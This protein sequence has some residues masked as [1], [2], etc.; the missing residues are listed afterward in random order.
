MATTQL[1]A[2]TRGL[3]L[4]DGI[5]S[6]KPDEALILNNWFPR[7]GYCQLRGG[8][9]SYATGLGSTVQSI[10]EWSGPATRKMFGATASAI[11]NT[12]SSGAVG[13]ADLSSLTSGYWQS[14]NFTTAGGA[15]LVICNGADSVRNYDGT[16]W[17][18]PSIT[19]VTSADLI[20]VAS[21]KSRLWF[22]QKD[23][24][25]AWYLGTSSISGAATSFEL[26]ERFTLGGALRAIGSIST[27]AGDAGSDDYL[28][29]VSSKGEVVV[30]R[31]TDPSSANT[32]ALVGVYRSA[33]PIGHRCLA[34]IGGDLG[35]LTEGGIVSV[36][37]LIAGGRD[38]AERGAVTARID[39]A[40]AD[41]FT[42]Y[43]SVT[44][45]QMIV[46]PRTRQ[47]IFNVP[48]STTE[49][50]Q[51]AMNVKTGAWCTYTSLNATCWG[52][53]NE[54]LY[55]GS[56]AG[57]VWK[58]EDGSADNGAAITGEIKYSFQPFGARGG[59]S[60]I[61]QVRPLF[62]AS[63]R[64][65]PAVRVDIDYQN[66][67][68]TSSDE[69]PVTAGTLGSAWDVG[70]WDVATWGDNSQLFGDWV[71]A[72]GIGT[73]ASVHLVTRTLGIEAKLNAVDVQYERAG[74]L[75][76]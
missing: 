63:G 45:W 46:H 23:S 70:L 13:A 73:V 26:G 19:G 35:L 17:T 48:T 47:A 16:N 18:T 37:Q 5:A 59:V 29:F 38:V 56:S 57:T 42:S 67:T 52:T 58:A 11:Y 22:V 55:F 53:L 34:K 32:W 51:Y 25:K 75:G 40:I 54:S 24:T 28:A 15:F 2:P 36:R 65:V 44:G 9:S 12:T 72:Q 10:L 60:R 1:P 3:N 7:E 69:Y 4:R 27:D 43:G 31:G 14:V 20:N 6:L 76:L 33:P 61:T 66:T 74:T 30:Y 71:A 50:Y 21:H 8:H 39:K 62:T 64:V 68:P 41:A 49:A